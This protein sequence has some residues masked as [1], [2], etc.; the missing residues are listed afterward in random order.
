[1]L[2]EAFVPETEGQ[3]VNCDPS[4][5][6]ADEDNES[7]TPNPLAVIAGDTVTAEL[8]AFVLCEIDP[9]E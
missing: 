4:F 3:Q 7:P 5:L 6:I 2:A 1:V 8:L 9:M